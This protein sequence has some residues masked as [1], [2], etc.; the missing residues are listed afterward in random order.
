MGRQCATLRFEALTLKCVDSRL[1]DQGKQAVRGG[2][3]VR[4]TPRRAGQRVPLA[5][6]RRARGVA[7]VTRLVAVRR[8][9]G[10][11]LVD[12]GLS[13]ITGMLGPVMVT[14]GPDFQTHEIVP[15]NSRAIRWKSARSRSFWRSEANPSPFRLGAAG[16]QPRPADRPSRNDGGRTRTPRCLG[17]LL[18]EQHVLHH[19]LPIAG[20]SCPSSRRTPMVVWPMFVWFLLQILS[21]TWLVSL[22]G[23]CLNLCSNP[24]ARA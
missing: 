22:F 6:K 7:P 10:R 24:K 12:L 15:S 18:V 20:H 5:C 14:E 3:P 21:K 1:T 8:G 9:G 13:I 16:G 4:W 11:N 23:L 19:F 17:V 2:T